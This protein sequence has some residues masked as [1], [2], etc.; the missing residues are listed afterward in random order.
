M[1]NERTTRNALNSSDVGIGKREEESKMKKNMRNLTSAI[2]VIGM[3][4]AASPALAGPKPNVNNDGYGQKLVPVPTD[5]I[6]PLRRLPNTRQGRLSVDVWT[7]VGEGG[8]VYPGEAVKVS[9]RT[10]RN[11]F[12]AVYS[13]DTRGRRTKLFPMYAG[14]EGFV[15]RGEKITL[16][17]RHDGYDLVAT[18]PAG[19]ERIVAI[20]S[21]QP[22]GHRAWRLLN[23]NVFPSGGIAGELG[24]LKPGITVQPAGGVGQSLRHRP[25]GRVAVAETWFEVE[26]RNKRRYR[27]R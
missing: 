26:R 22:L 8:Y 14:D 13:I 2:T 21:K 25:R 7:N 17:G 4:A 15:N 9:F 24:C 11:A 1:N 23:S 5:R 19:T 27:R 18:G 6:E 16:G 12:V 3:L 20:A 10:N